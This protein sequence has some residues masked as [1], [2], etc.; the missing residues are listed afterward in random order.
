[1]ESVAW[2]V[3]AHSIMRR[4]SVPVAITPIVLSNFNKTILTRP[5]DPKQSNDFAFSRWLVPYLCNY[6]GHAIFMDCD[7]LMRGDIAELW[8]AVDNRYSVQVVKHDYTPRNA[9]KFL[10][11]E[12]TTYEMKNWSSVMLFN[13]TACRVL[14]PEYVNAV[15]GLSLHQFKWIQNRFVG[16]LDPKW[17]WLVGEYE[18]NPHAANVHFTVGGP[19]FQEYADCDYSQEWRREYADM[20]HCAQLHG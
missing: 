14:T 16:A 2:H 9:S 13:N 18:H 12:Q 6:E 1:M 10:G 8:E 5:R 7:M 19:Y 3:L 15:S 17:N 20:T 11:Q 4:S